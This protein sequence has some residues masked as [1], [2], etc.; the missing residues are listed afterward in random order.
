MDTVIAAKSSAFDCFRF[1]KAQA[2]AQFLDKAYTIRNLRSDNGGEF[3]SNAFSAFLD[4][5]GVH[6]QLT[7]PYTP[8]Q[9]GVVERGNRTIVGDIRTTLQASGL[10]KSFWAEAAATSV[11]IRNRLPTTGVAGRTPY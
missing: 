7:A 6:R 11:Y 8:Q 1:Y 10:P 4:Q 3:I 5:G 2:E 9:N